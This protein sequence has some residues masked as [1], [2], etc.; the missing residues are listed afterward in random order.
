MVRS[1]YSLRVNNLILKLRSI[2]LQS[3][4]KPF[5]N[6]FGNI[7]STKKVLNFFEGKKLKNRKI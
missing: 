3:M 5:F 6:S 4:L 7:A 2:G 1:I